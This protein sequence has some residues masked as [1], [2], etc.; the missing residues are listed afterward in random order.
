MSPTPPPAPIVG[1]LILVRHGQSTFNAHNRFTGWSDPELT[2]KGEAEARSVADRLA[3]MGVRVDA[4]FSSGFQRTVRSLEIILGALGSSTIAH[5]DM[6]LNERSYG[7]LTGL[8][9]DEAGARFGAEQIQHWRRSYAD[10]PPGGESLRDTVARVVPYYLRAILPRALRGE[11]VLVVAHG[12][13]L[14]ALVMAL[15]DISPFAVQ[16]LEIATGE[17]LDYS[18]AADATVTRVHP[19]EAP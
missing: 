1:Q 10:A 11:T 3:R 17:I 14:R 2:E 8:D 6:A 18:V 7:E 13:T 9:K 19:L 4:A 12:N 16:G 5:A 15:D